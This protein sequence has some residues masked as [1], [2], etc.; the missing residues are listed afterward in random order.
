M[1]SNPKLSSET[2]VLQRVSEILNLFS[3]EQPTV[4]V[5][6]VGAV[7]NV[8]QATAYRYLHDLHDIGLLSRVSGSYVPGPKII[9][10]EFIFNRYDPVLA[11]SKDLMSQLSRQIGCD[12]LLSRLYGL[13]LVNVASFRPTSFQELRFSPGRRMPMFKGSQARVVLAAMDRRTRRRVFD[14]GEGDAGRDQIGANWPSFNATL[15]KDKRKGYY[16]SYG[17]LDLGIT[18]I[19]APVFDEDDTVLGSLVLAYASDAPPIQSEAKLI[20]ITK[21]SANEITHRIKIRGQASKANTAPD[22]A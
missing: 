15:Q 5:A 12:V 14:M 17:E 16:V 11:A 2:S 4:D 7:L 10:L 22:L 13:R 6:S 21:S 8:S 19:A 1:V 3:E 20:E 18:G 9:E